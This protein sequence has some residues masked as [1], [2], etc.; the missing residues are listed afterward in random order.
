[1]NLRS[2]AGGAFMLLSAAAMP[3][4]GWA[5]PGDNPPPEPL[6]QAP[7]QQK[8][9][10][11]VHSTMQTDIGQY[12][13]GM[14]LAYV[15]TTNDSFNRM[16]ELGLK[17]LAF[18]SHRRSTMEPTGVVG[19]DIENDDLSFFPFLLFQVTNDTPRLSDQARLKVQQYLAN[20]GEIFF[21]VLSGRV[22]ESEPLKTMLNDLQISQPQLLEEG[23]AL[24]QSFY[25]VSELPGIHNRPVWVESD[26]PSM[27][28]STTSVIIGSNN[29]AGAWSG[30]FTEPEVTEKA[31]RAGL[32]MFS[33]SLAGNYKTD[34]VHE[35]TITMKRENQRA[36]ERRDAERLA[37][38]PSGE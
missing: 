29:W 21:D 10:L 31:L 23:H 15:R 25:L 13:N 5:A 18:E 37:P 7:A 38:A 14:F 33:F 34:P 22:N 4:N 6:Q 30:R 11:P 35:E 1:M 2:A 9:F 26:N 17:N 12:A 19:V 24:T 28:E 16:A 3:L 36:A 32:N 20:G 27:G 8:E